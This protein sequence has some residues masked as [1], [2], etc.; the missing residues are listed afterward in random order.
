MV[1]VL[2]VRS[3]K[4]LSIITPAVVFTVFKF[5]LSCYLVIQTFGFLPRVRADPRA[6]VPSLAVRFSVLWGKGAREII[7]FITRAR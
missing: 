6:S 5:T 4:T 1:N 2:L 7:K 3:T